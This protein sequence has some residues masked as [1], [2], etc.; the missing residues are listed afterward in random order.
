[1]LADLTTQTIM[2]ELDGH[3]TDDLSWLADSHAEVHQASGM[4]QV[5]LQTSTEAALLQLRAYA[6]SHELL[7][8]EVARRVVARELHFPLCYE[9]E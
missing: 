1:M 9:T 4:V 8:S 5:Q 3:A 2:T 7:L 6:F